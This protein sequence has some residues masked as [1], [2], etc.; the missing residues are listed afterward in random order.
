MPKA[1]E[2]QLP[3]ISAWQSQVLRLT[4]FPLQVLP[5]LEQSWWNDLVGEPPENS[6]S[7][8]RKPMRE[9][10]GSFERGTLTLKVGPKRIDWLYTARLHP[11]EETEE[12][13][14]TGNLPG[15]VERF[16]DLMRQWLPACPATKRLAFGAVL[17]QPVDNRAS[18]YDLLNKYLHCVEVDGDST[19]LLYRINR[20][21]DSASGITA[22]RV[23][24][25]SSWSVMKVQ[26]ALC[27][28][29]A[30]EAIHEKIG[31]ES[32]ACRLELDMNTQP[33]F[34]NEL[35]REHMP[36]LLDELINLGLEIAS[37][38]DVK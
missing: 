6:V 19:D 31:P 33:E 25:L 22:L 30:D 17:V 24:R 29:S 28:I 9:D 10:E 1:S 13:P 37:K 36:Q 35:P 27:E 16:L 21:R 3:D 8:P 38:G 15:P 5:S 14:N 4:A 26:R 32:F 12:I 7:Q 2:G 11:E 34:E 23:N 18:G 20:P